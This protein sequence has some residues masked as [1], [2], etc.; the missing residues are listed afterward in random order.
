[1]VEAG[2]RAVMLF[3]IQRMDT[4]AFAPAADLDPAYAVGL[5][6][7]AKAGVEVL[8]YDCDLTF[9]SIRIARRI[10]WRAAQLETA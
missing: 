10:P 5:T 1:M 3:V 6:A 7:A 8:C 2:D 9:E 4:D